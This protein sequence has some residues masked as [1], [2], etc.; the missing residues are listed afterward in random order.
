M[1][2]S[3]KKDS[4][5]DSIKTIRSALYYYKTEIVDSL[6]K[7]Y[8]QRYDAIIIIYDKIRKN[9]TTLID[10]TTDNIKDYETYKKMNN[11]SISLE[12]QYDA[13]LQLNQQAKN[14]FINNNLSEINF[15]KNNKPALASMKN[16]Y[17][18]QNKY[19]DYLINN[20]D[21][22]KALVKKVL[23]KNEEME[24]KRNTQNID[25]LKTTKEKSKRLSK[26]NK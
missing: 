5:D 22:R 9:Y 25:N 3:R 7:Q 14:G 24:K 20:E 8:F 10:W 13:S 26:K 23:E 6:Q 1:A 15:I 19:F 2:R 18:K 17:E 12:N 16:V 4:F 11:S 21:D